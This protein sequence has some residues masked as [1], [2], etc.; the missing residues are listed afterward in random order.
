M[1]YIIGQICVFG[2]DY[3]LVFWYFFKKCY[4]F[5]KFKSNKMINLT[6]KFF[7]VLQ[8]SQNLKKK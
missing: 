8:A 7:P 3:I 2:G 6:D 1:K 4:R 5:H